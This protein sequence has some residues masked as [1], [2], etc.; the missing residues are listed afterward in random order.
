[1]DANKDFILPILEATYGR[2][3]AVCW[4]HRWRMFFLAVAELFGYEHGR[5]WF[6]SH[7]LL[8]HPDQSSV[9]N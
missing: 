9:A 5:Q 4:F 6:V 1:M 3:D 7:Y 8:K 2:A